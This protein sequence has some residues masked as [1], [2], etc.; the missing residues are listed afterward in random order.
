MDSYSIL[1]KH[2]NEYT[3]LM[4]LLVYPNNREPMRDAY[5]FKKATDFVYL[6]V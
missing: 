3:A 5:L 2:D 6:N 4:L 1:S